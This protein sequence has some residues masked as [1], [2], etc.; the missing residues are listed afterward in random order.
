LNPA[1]IFSHSLLRIVPPPATASGARLPSLAPGE[2]LEGTVL[3]RSEPDRVLI[4]IKGQDLW[5]RS[6]VALPTGARVSFKAETAF[7]PVLLRIL[8]AAGEEPA[9]ALGNF[10]RF[11]AE[12][13]PLSRLAGKLTGLLEAGPA[14]LP[15]A[16]DEILREL[17]TAL[18]QYDGPS[19]GDSKTLRERISHSGLFF[20]NRLQTLIRNPGGDE[21]AAPGRRDLKGLLLRLKSLLPELSAGERGND[22]AL[23]RAKEGLQSVEPYLQRIEAYQ[24]LNQRYGDSSE[25]W[26][27]LLPLWFG[28]EMRFLE[29]ELKFERK[30]GASAPEEETSLIFLLD[31]PEAGRIRIEATIRKD[32]LFCRFHSSS[33]ALR[34]EI[35]RNLPE[36]EPRLQALGF[37][38]SLAVFAAPLEEEKEAV[39]DRLDEQGENLVS[40]VI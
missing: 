3:A 8:P 37:R 4:R 23:S 29:M 10:K 6:E 22:P 32:G 25:K 27:L 7:P 1:K 26:L 17:K 15:P 38:P 9:A 40:V 31:L 28:L 39:A 11:F 35:E 5:A 20:E 30:N 34:A 21:L 14:G 13:L 24:L 16:A 36:L 33:P 12:S 2:I 18:A 19:L